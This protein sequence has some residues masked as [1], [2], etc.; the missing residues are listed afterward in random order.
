MLSPSGEPPSAAVSGGG[1]VFVGGGS[2][3]IMLFG[4]RV[5]VDPMRKSVS[6]NNLSEYE[7]VNN[8]NN[9]TCANNNDSESLKTATATTNSYASADDAVPQSGNGSRERKRGVPWTEEEHRLFLV[10]LQKAGKGDW[11]GIS[12]N[13]VKTRTPTQ[14][15]SHA[16]KYF[17][18]RNNR[19]RRRRRSSLFDITTDSVTAIPN[20]EGTSHQESAAQAILPPTSLP[21]SETSNIGGIPV[22]VAAGES[23]GGIAV[24]HL[25]KLAVQSSPLTSGL[26]LGL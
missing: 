17:L 5:K 20:N 11:R 1:N 22:G 2:G 13:Y 12:R 23:S 24:Q 25:S 4:V 8:N 9:N 14:V 19:N 15:A 16:Q 18:R 10:G 7:P 21:P 6:M 3:E 26:N